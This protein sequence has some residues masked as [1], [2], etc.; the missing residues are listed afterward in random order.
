MPIVSQVYD[1][2]IGVDTHART[3]TLVV[4]N[5][6]GAKLAADTFPTSA[7]G[8]ARAQAWMIRHAGGRVLVAMEGTGSYGAGFT[9]RLLHA[10]I[11]VVETKPPK[12]ADR[13]AGKSD[14][15]DA[16]HA[17]RHV[18][19]TPCPQLLT[20]RKHDGDQAALRVLLTIRLAKTKTRTALTN[21]L[22]ALLRGHDLDYD[23]R[24][25]P[26][27]AQIRTIAGWRPRTSDPDWLA[28]IRTEATNTAKAII[29]ADKE[30]TANNTNL[31][32]HVT[33]TAAWLLAEPGIGPFVAANLIIAYS[34]PGRIH[35][36]AAFAR[37]AGIAPIPASSGNTNRYRLHR[38]GDRQLNHAIWV[39][40]KSRKQY[41]NDTKTYVAKRTAEG[42]T[43]N[44]I[45]RCLKR[46]IIRQLFRKIQQ[47]A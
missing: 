27:H 19:S 1:Y 31:T 30:L 10:G 21:A 3:H 45:T 28:T 7:P 42:K 24:R 8:L 12:R 34:S 35:S 38:G 36:E 33:N 5:A 18:L 22:I 20:P 37:L 39:I 9:D 16:E 43:K 4:L 44:E 25:K 17:A 40:T 14:A 29:A 47:H 26:S 41:H 11:T 2:V 46:H 13:P 6:A 32:R 23:A 15:I